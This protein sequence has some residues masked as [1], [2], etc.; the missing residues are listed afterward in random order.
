MVNERKR[1]EEMDLKEFED[2]LVCLTS[3]LKRDG[4]YAKP[5][6][7][8]LHVFGKLVDYESQIEIIMKRIKQDIKEETRSTKSIFD[9]MKAEKEIDDKIARKSMHALEKLML[10]LSDFFVYTR[11][12]L[13]TLT[14]SIKLTLKKSGTK[15]A[16]LLKHSVKCL[17]NPKSMRIYKEKI[18]CH[19][20]TGLEQHLTWVRTFRESRDGLVHQYYHFVFTSTRAGKKGFEIMDLKKASWGT[21][22]VKEI[23]PEL[24]Q[25]VDN[26]S[27]LIKYLTAELPRVS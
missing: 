14:M 4:F 15:N 19:F 6:R 17:L 20:F 23:M 22:T 3:F 18:D 8:E 5:N 9:A 21:V 2:S 11:M 16:D 13:D 12:F 7:L 25:T 1:H 27:E 24:Q 26:L 10:D